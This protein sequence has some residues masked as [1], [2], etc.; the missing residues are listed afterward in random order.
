M[1]G[2][3]MRTVKK[4]RGIRA[5][6]RGISPLVATLI[7]ILI[8]IVG[9]G[10]IYTVMRDQSTTLSTQGDIKLISASITVSEDNCILAVTVKNTGTVQLSDVKA[11][12]VTEGGEL[13]TFDISPSPLPPGETGSLAGGFEVLP[14]DCWEAGKT[15]DVMVIGKVDGAFVTDSVKVLARA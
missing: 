1:D 15:Y 6:V 10:V 3:K 14:G 7:L 13:A 12:V 11:K 5:G 9:G 2:E 4:L 8:T